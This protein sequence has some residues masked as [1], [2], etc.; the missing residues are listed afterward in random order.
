MTNQTLTA[1]AAEFMAKMGKQLKES[2]GI[3]PELYG[4]YDVKRSLRDSSGAGVL[5]GLT[6]IGEVDGYL[7]DANYRHIPINGELFYRGYNVRD[8]M[9]SAIADDRFGYEEASYLLLFGKLP[10]K[11]ELEEYKQLLGMRRNL[12]MGFAR[13]MILVAPSRNLMNKLARSVLALYSYDENPDD[14]SIENVLRQSIDLIACFPS[15]MAYAYQAKRSSYDNASLSLHYPDPEKS[16]AENILR[17]I[18]PTGEY[19]DLEA[20]MLDRSMILHAEHGGG[21]NSTFTVRMITSAGSDTYSAI[22]AACASLKGPRHGGASPEVLEMIKDLKANVKDTGN[23][24][25]IEQYLHSLLKGEAF[26]RK[27]RIY[28][29]GHAVY[30]LT[31]PRTSFLKDIAR[32]LAKEKDMMDEFYIYEFIEEHGADLIA[33]YHEVDQPIAVNVDL[34]SAFLAYALGIPTELCRPIFA[35][36]RIS[37]WCAHRLEELATGNKIMRPAYINILSQKEYIPINNR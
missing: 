28:G 35:T 16:T 3:A 25:Q 10:S 32:T 37:G 31:D 24:K 36:S 29:L 9:Q 22:A 2:I 11:K 4:E 20:K 27:G 5:V 33:Q 23:P 21:C 14:L 34:Y 15:L 6:Q 13:D 19:S 8:L 1:E 17:M 12:P 7:I 18:R 30:T 26:D